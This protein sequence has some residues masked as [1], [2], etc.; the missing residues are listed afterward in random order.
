MSL[1]RNYDI[2]IKI[3]NSLVVDGLGMEV[4]NVAIKC[5]SNNTA[6]CLD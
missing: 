1:H 3:E 5:S 2:I 4:V 6:K